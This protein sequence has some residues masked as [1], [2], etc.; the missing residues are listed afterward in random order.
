[1]PKKSKVALS[2]SVV[3]APIGV[4]EETRQEM[5]VLLDD[6]PIVLSTASTHERPLGGVIG[7]L[8]AKF[9]S[10][11]HRFVDERLAITLKVREAMA[12]EKNKQKQCRPAWS[13]KQ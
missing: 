1:M 12:S 8:D 13:Q 5:P 9:V 3:T 6:E 2:V 10:E 7:E 11:A 4:T